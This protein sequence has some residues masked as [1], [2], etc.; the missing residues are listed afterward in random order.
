LEEKKIV[1]KYAFSDW[2][3]SDSQESRKRSAAKH[4]IFKP[5]GSLNICFVTHCGPDRDRNRYGLHFVKENDWLA[6]CNEENF[7]Y[8]R[9]A[10]KRSRK[11]VA[12]E[13]GAWI[14]GYLADAEKQEHNSPGY[15]ADTVHDLSKVNLYGAALAMRQATSLYVLGYSLPEKDSWLR[16]RIEA[17]DRK[18]RKI[19][20]D[21]TPVYVASKDDS[22]RIL[23]YFAELRFKKRFCIN[24][25]DI[26]DSPNWPSSR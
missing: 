19:N 17:L 10:K 24:N 4:I 22:G 2:I 6:T 11:V 21:T 14:I 3:S 13:E 15:F 23:K 5:H 12:I 9:E 8:K 25:G 18:P 7:G 1:W 20:P 26:V 16:R